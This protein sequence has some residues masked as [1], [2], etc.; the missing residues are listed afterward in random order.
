M[1][2]VTNRM[3][4]ILVCA[5]AL[6]GCGGGGGGGGNSPPPPSSFTIG[7]TVTGL[8]GSGLVLQNS[9]GNPLT[10]GAN[11]AFTFSSAVATGGAYNV[12]VATHPSNPTQ[13]C[14]IIG[15]SGT[16][17][18]A[19]VTSVAVSCT[20]TT[21]NVGGSVTGLVASGL[22]LQNNAA[23]DLP[24]AASGDF[25]FTTRVASGAPYAVTVRTQPNAGPAQTCSVTNGGGTVTTAA[26]TTVNVTCTTQVARFLYSANTGSNNV[27]A[28][29]IDAATGTLT[30]VAGSPFPANVGP[31][32]IAANRAGSSLYVSSEGAV[33]TPPRISAY[34]INGTTGALTQVTNSP[35]ELSPTPFMGPSP[36][37]RP[38]VHPSGA[39]V[40]MGIRL[41]SFLYGATVDPASGN[42]T[43]IPNL[44]Q[45]GVGQQFGA[46]D[47]AG[48]VLY[49]PND[50]F[51]GGANGAIS[52][53]TAATPSG[54]LTPLGS[55]ATG[56]RLPGGIT[57]NVA[58]TFLL[59][60]NNGSGTVSV[61]AVDAVSGALSAAPGSPFST[62]A[63]TAP[64][65]VWIHRNGK[66]VYVSNT[67]AHPTPSS[68]AAFQ[69]DATTGALTPV[70]GSPFSTAGT[71]AAVGTVDP[72]GKFLFVANS[73]SSN[74]QAFAI[75][76]VTGVLTPV[77][78]SP[79]AT[80]LAPAPLVV[81]PSGKYLYTANTDDNSM[82]S[83]AIN[84]TT[85]ALTLVNTVAAGVRPRFPELV[86]LQ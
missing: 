71:L 55:F 40:Y 19:N 49:L 61:F 26:V 17:G 85:G 46:F 68:I 35:F 42:L 83:Y 65:S 75:D 78:G 11:G 64:T 38:I 70:A 72:S 53:Y 22:V 73:G 66:F 18:S 25:T 21:F 7:G 20:T 14:T 36:S 62:G 37:V 80:E 39:S 59:S 47:A 9:G 69:L 13:T 2:A 3:T 67:N 56:G 15:N 27:S 28:Y 82:S 31:L 44:P 54:A 5:L 60:A 34:S 1:P 77:P 29:A 50:N 58:G 43:P 23:N 8:A 4:L 74:I 48:K 32:F 16:V 30:S 79:F 76:Q 10:V 57:L 12:S 63:G 33:N 6:A 24:I 84:P 41:S 51:N 52:A 45:V 81:D 86:G